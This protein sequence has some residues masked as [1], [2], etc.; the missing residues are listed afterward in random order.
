MSSKK[1][2]Q[3]HRRLAAERRRAAMSGGEPKMSAV[4]LELAEPLLKRYGDT[5]SLSHNIIALTIAAW[6]KAVLP[7]DM[8]EGFDEKVLQALG[9]IGNSRDGREVIAYT[10]NLIAERT[11][12]YYP[13]LRKYIVSFDIDVL[14]GKTSLNVAS[15]ALP[16]DR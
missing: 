9:P 16:A 13:N 7:A 6:N 11:K 1:N 14:E 12:Q 5:P 2:K 15:A 10:M 4:I 8:Q 3:R